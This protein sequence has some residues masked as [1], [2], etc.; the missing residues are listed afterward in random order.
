[1]SKKPTISFQYVDFNKL[2]FLENNPRTRT[3]KGLDTMAT[4]IKADPTFYE[5]RPTLVN[6]TDGEYRVYAGDLRAH[7]AHNKLGW[8]QVPCNVENDVPQKVMERRAILDN[9]HREGW[10][11]E[12]MEDWD[13]TIEDFV[14]M[15]V[16]E[17]VFGLD[18]EGDI[19][20]NALNSEKKDLPE[21]S[22]VSVKRWIPDC[23]FPSNNKYEIP[24]LMAAMQADILSAPILLWGSEK[25]T[26]KIDGGTV[27]FYVDDYRFEAI[28]SDPSIVSDTGC[29]S[30]V[31]PNCSLYDSMPISFGLHQ[32]Y[33][34][35]WV[36]RWLQSVGV[37]VFV[38]LNVSGKF[39]EYNLLGVPDGWNAFCT[40]G[41]TERVEHLLLEISIAQ[42]I[43]GQ[44]NPFMVVY[45]GG[46]KIRDIAQR[47]NL[48]YL[49]QVRGFGLTD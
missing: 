40:R 49:E 5:N 47:N 16:P 22:D 26:K 48:I 20:N 13:F 18:D 28:W 24:T 41:Y 9:T 12:K 44:S 2:V 39:A 4:D 21:D 3:A 10:D 14:D 32:I 23:I 19:P 29:L 35:R 33:K 1:M 8:K 42:K 11:S 17:F 36:A 43:S 45:G 46:D 38:D 34:K 7:A 15:G 27:L 30:I 25:R 37:K 31:E 6:F